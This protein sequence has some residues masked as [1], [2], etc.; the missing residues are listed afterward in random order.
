MEAL[1][2]TN[3]TALSGVIYLFMFIAACIP[4]WV[5]IGLGVKTP[6][7]EIAHFDYA[8]K[9]A[10]LHMPKVYEQYGQT[11]LQAVACDPELQSEAWAAISDCNAPYQD[12][13]NAPFFGQ[14]SA[15]SYAPT[16]YSVIALNYRICSATF[17]NLIDASPI[18]CMRIANSLLAGISV[19]LIVAIGML[20]GLP[21]FAV[22]VAA[23]ISV[24]SPAM[25]QQFSTVNSDAGALL[26]VVLC[27]FFAAWL[28]TRVSPKK[29]A[30]PAS[31]SFISP[32]LQRASLLF[33]VLSSLSISM[34]ETSLLIA[35]TASYLFLHLLNKEKE[36][37]SHSSKRYSFVTSLQTLIMSAAIMVIVSGI[38][39]SQ[40]RIR[41]LGGNDWMGSTLR[42]TRKPFVDEI[43]QPLNH[44]LISGDQTV[45]EIYTDSISRN[46]ATLLALI[47]VS[48][49]MLGYVNWKKLHINQNK[50]L[51]TQI[52]GNSFQIGV[53]S[54]PIM[55]TLL[56]AFS[57]VQAGFVSS[58]PRYYLPVTI[59]FSCF[60][61]SVVFS[62]TWKWIAPT[63]LGCFSILLYISFFQL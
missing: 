54:L 48:A 44:L 43:L 33:I 25:V 13:M 6:F 62:A 24:N 3:K 17:G 38:R 7:D 9:I 14:S 27:V 37:S 52:F 35:P 18:T 32:L 63:V 4:S 5:S 45:A 39:W 12:P 55:A 56:G 30:N 41:G 49:S 1:N 59:L 19:L 51:T 23:L 20:I 34:K 8:E 58:Q 40:P 21:R 15:T 22:A 61:L 10:K 26:A 29:E 31:E 28:P 60:S 57:L 36:S 2:R 42:E 46:L 50:V 16:Y 53:F 11:T 47:F